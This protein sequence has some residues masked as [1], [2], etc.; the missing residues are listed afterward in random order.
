[1]KILPNKIMPR[2]RNTRRGGFILQCFT[3]RRIFRVADKGS[4]FFIVTQMTTGQALQRH[5]VIE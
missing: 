1:M 2:N 4:E 5:G 3:I